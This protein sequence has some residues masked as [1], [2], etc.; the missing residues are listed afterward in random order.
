MAIFLSHPGPILSLGRRWL[1]YPT[2]TGVHPPGEGSRG[3]HAGRHRRGE[4]HG[5]GKV[6][7]RGELHG[8]R[9]GIAAGEKR[10]V[11]GWLYEPGQL[12]LLPLLFALLF[13]R[14]RS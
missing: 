5:S 14:F 12:C 6:P 2:P 1:L 11:A 9:L 8:G 10:T 13:L 7:L 3:V 4:A